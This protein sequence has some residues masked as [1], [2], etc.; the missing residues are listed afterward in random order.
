[1]LA[2]YQICHAI[3]FDG[4]QVFDDKRKQLLECTVHQLDFSISL[5]L[6]SMPNSILEMLYL[7]VSFAAIETWLVLYY[8]GVMLYGK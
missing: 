2:Y 8:I 6:P 5:G 3:E 4:W 1:M 7:E